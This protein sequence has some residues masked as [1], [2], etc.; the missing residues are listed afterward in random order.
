M[1]HYSKKQSQGQEFLYIINNQDYSELFVAYE[2]L[3]SGS[4]DLRVLISSERVRVFTVSS[5]A[6]CCV[7]I[8]TH[9][10]DLLQCQTVSPEEESNSG[11]NRH[12]IELTMKLSDPPIGSQDRIKRPRIRCDNETIAKWVSRQV[13]Y[14]KRMFEQRTNT[15]IN[16][17]DNI[18]E[19]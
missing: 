14:A 17:G 15:L 4:D 10:G 5:S 3:R 12:Y 7:V 6:N 2:Y 9:L 11:G 13:N 16:I 19:D 1:P 18:F 8:E